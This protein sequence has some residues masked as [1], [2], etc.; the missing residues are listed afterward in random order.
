MDITQ[1]VLNMSWT[2]RID[3]QLCSQPVAYAA[4]WQM[5]CNSVEASGES[6]NVIYD[7]YLFNVFYLINNRPT[8]VS[9][10]CD[11]VFHNLLIF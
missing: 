8:Y 1:P 5:F 10:E 7:D 4:S 6:V 3:I 2:G 11:S 9:T